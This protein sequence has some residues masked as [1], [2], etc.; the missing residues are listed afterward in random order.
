MVKEA[1]Q[2]ACS[3]S[4]INDKSKLS[5]GK[6]IQY[7]QLAIQSYFKAGNGLTSETKRRI[8]QVRL[9]DI[10]IRG[11]FKGKHSDIKCK[12]PGCN[13][14][15]TQSHVFQSFC[16]YTSNVQRLNN[17]V[18]YEGIFNNNVSSQALVADIIFENLF[19]RSKV[20]PAPPVMSEGPEEP[21]KRGG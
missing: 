14:D 3:Y 15:E 13:Q 12:I 8:V 21:R 6:E 20:I 4:L 7:N 9:R 19:K 5:K 11:N 10:A 18:Q 17:D 2:K 1:A 16:M